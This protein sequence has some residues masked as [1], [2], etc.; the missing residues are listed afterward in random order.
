Y[1]Y[2]YY[3]HVFVIISI[4]TP[5]SFLLFFFFS[6]IPRPPI[7]TLFPYTTLFRSC[8][9]DIFVNVIKQATQHSRTVTSKSTV[10]N[11]GRTT[12]QRPRKGCRIAQAPLSP[13]FDPVFSSCFRKPYPSFRSHKSTTALRT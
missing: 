1:D 5:S 13:V 12:V 10:L 4:F 6:M 8:V 7:S 11:K 3:R 9:T 2:L